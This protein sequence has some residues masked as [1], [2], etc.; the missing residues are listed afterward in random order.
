MNRVINN[1]GALN[2]NNGVG[3]SVELLTDRLASDIL[4]LIDKHHLS[5]EEIIALEHKVVGCVA[6]TCAENILREAIKMRKTVDISVSI[7]VDTTKL[8]EKLVKI[9]H[10]A[11]LKNHKTPAEWCAI[12]GVEVI[13]PDGWDRKDPNCMSYPI[14]QDQFIEKYQRSTVGVV[15]RAKFFPFRHLFG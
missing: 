7:K 11:Y 5:P 13:D 10:T 9:R 1:Y 8:K 14:T 4:T 3:Y 12:F 6:T 2:I 15:D